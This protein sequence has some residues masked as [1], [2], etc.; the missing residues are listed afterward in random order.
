VEIRKVAVVRSLDTSD[1]T[2]VTVLGA[3]Q[4][5]Q[6]EAVVID[7][8]LGFVTSRI[9]ALIGN[10]AFYMLMEEM[11]GAEDIDRAVNSGLKH[12]MGPLELADPV[13]LDVRPRNLQYLQ[14]ML[15]D[16]YRKCPLL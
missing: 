4:H 1:E 5:M 16:K 7:E 6:K 3:V 2:C 11:A 12:P 15:G 8:S 14:K 9:N 13:G 10:E